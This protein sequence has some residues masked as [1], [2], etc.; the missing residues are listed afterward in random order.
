MTDLYTKLG[1]QEKALHETRSIVLNTSLS[2]VKAENDELRQSVRIADNELKIIGLREEVRILFIR[3]SILICM[4]IL[5]IFGAI[6]Y[7]NY[8]TEPLKEKSV[9]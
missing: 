3:I 9:T 5:K 6:L 8:T 4:V 1:M 7:F 2:K